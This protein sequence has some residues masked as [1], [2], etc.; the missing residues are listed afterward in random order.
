MLAAA[1]NDIPI[2]KRCSQLLS[3]DAPTKFTRKSTRSLNSWSKQTKLRVFI[4]IGRNQV[5]WSLGMFW[6]YA[7]DIIVPSKKSIDLYREIGT[8]LRLLLLSP[9]EALRRVFV[10]PTLHGTSSK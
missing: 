10:Q 8:P 6:Y 3:H 7:E 4:N 9:Q 2:H 5:V 1:C